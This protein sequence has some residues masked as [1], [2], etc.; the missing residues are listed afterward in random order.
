MKMLSNR[1]RAALFC[2]VLLATPTAAPAGVVGP[3]LKEVALPAAHKSPAA[4]KFS[5]GNIVVIHRAGTRRPRPTDSHVAVL[6]RNGKERLVTTPGLDV[7]G[8]RVASVVDAIVTAD[9]VLVV[10]AYVWNE[11]GK[12]ASLLMSYNVAKQTLLRTVRTN[13]VACEALAA[14]GANIWCIGVDVEKFNSGDS[15]YNVL[16]EFDA[17][18]KLLRSRIRSSE[19]AAPAFKQ[20]A[21]AGPQIVA[22]D[23]GFVAWLP[24]SEALFRLTNDG[25]LIRR[26]PLA[27]TPVDFVIGDALCLLPGGRLVAVRTTASKLEGSPLP[28]RGLFGI[29]DDGEITPLGGSAQELPAG[30]L[31]AGTD[32]S[33]LVFY[34]ALSR[35][36]VWLSPPAQNK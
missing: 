22:G 2:S 30:Y 19:I 24:A 10:S 16:H 17:D 32:G 28:R 25:S 26:A 1:V 15:D 36:V 13:P 8:T 12:S 34:S 27:P 14:V 11:D 3:P 33:R 31:L 20:K 23:Q 7:E 21:S 35:S 5:A 18:G 4:V 6:D 29:G 9:D